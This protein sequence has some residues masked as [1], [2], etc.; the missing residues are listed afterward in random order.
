MSIS[1]PWA[2]GGTAVPVGPYPLPPL[3]FGYA[4]LEP[5]IDEATLWLHH[6]QHH[7][8]YVEKTNAALARFPQWLGLSI[9]ELLRR[10]PE[11][12][13][14][15]R[16]AI[17]Q[18]GG[19]HANHQF[20][21]KILAPP[22]ARVPTGDLAVFIR[23]DF[24]SFENFQAQFEAEGNALVGSGWV[25]LVARPHRDYRLEILTLANQDSVLTS[26]DPAPGL[27]ICDV[28]EHAYYLRYQNRRA[29]WLQAF[30]QVVNWDYV[31][32]RLEGVRRGRRQL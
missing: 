23:R 13:A 26:P 24:G 4:A 10:L 3:P 18:F 16:E 30:W 21:W 31:G 14:E 25:F 28:W 9:E 8:A 15:I 20:F 11:V 2:D 17:R 5:V 19:G 27:L 32:A 6:D 12:P 1:N 29:E 7:R 22:A